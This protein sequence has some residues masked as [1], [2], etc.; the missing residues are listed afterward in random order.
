MTRHRALIL[1]TAIVAVLSLPSTASAGYDF[2]L[3]GYWPL[4]EGRGQVARDWSGNGNH[5]QLG[6]TPGVDANDPSWIK[7]AFWWSSALHFDGGEFVNIPDSEDLETQQLTVSTWFRNAGSPGAHR[8][9]VAKGS[10]Q[11]IKSSYGLY[12]GPGGGLAF[13]VA[14]AEELGF[15]SS[16][17][18]P[19]TV[20]DGKWHNAAGTYD[21]QTVRLFIDGQEIGTG[22]PND[23]PVYYG[24]PAG[25]ST[26][27]AYGGTCDLTLFGDLDEVSIWK[28]ALPVAEIWRKYRVFFAPH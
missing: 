4:N 2:P 6:S 12:T 1:C 11:C 28:K 18:A 24:L 16:P 10:D 22:T 25:N 21:G 14:D 7:G 23:K 8:Y 19:P 15:T 13:Y 3:T 9:L 5:G 17:E 20:W 27:G 26:L